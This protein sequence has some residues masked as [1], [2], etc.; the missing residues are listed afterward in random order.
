MFPPFNNV[1]ICNKDS[2]PQAL[3]KIKVNRSYYLELESIN[4]CQNILILARDLVP[5]ICHLHV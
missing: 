4:F 3:F 5:L 2:S 1:E